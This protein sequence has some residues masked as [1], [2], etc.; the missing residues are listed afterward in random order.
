MELTGTPLARSSR[1]LDSTVTTIPLM[2][3]S[4]PRAPEGQRDADDEVERRVEADEALDKYDISTLAC[5][6]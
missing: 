3:T 6:D 5:T 2:F 4:S 1:M